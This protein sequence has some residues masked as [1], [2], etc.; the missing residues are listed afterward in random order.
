MRPEPESPSSIRDV[1]RTMMADGITAEVVRALE[2]AD[3]RCILLKGPALARWLYDERD[4]RTYVDCDLMVAPED[5]PR[6]ENLLSEKGFR[7]SGFDSIAGDWPKHARTWFR[8]D[9]GNV[10]LH[11]TLVG[12]GVSDAELWELLSSRT[13]R[14]H[15]LGVEVE[16]L[17]LAGR[18]LVLTLHAAK[19]G[20]RVEK[21]RRDLGKA[22]ERVPLNVWR[23]AAELAVRLDA[24]PGFAAGL[25]LLPEGRE[26][27][28]RLNLASELRMEAALRMSGGPPPLA[29]GL[30]W[31][32]NEPGLR[33]RAVLAFRKMFPPR[34]YL[35]TWTPIARS[36]PLGL[37]VARAWRPFWV[38][39][40]LGPAFLAWRRA[41]RAVK[42]SG[43]EQ[44]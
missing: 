12:V 25:R 8:E 6:A 1:A 22:L 35:R 15:V 38:I 29:A 20:P 34:A 31:M 21:I 24:S 23:E 13:E 32:A 36:G 10:D 41:R 7:L 44:E 27:A 9:S 3:I 37:A 28:R 26:L 11:H 18:A 42:R 43:S 5:I 19:D 2:T 16:V 39:W 40:H 30:E 33:R 17:T 14:M 4:V